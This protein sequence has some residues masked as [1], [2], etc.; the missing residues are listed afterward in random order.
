MNQL[1]TLQQH[2]QDLILNQLNIK[3]LTIVVQMKQTV[4]TTILQKIGISKLTIT[5]ILLFI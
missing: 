2:E 1:S 3:G 4:I 5:I